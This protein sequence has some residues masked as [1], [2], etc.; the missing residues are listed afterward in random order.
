METRQVLLEILHRL[1]I[2][3]QDT[4]DGPQVV[5]RRDRD[6]NIPQSRTNRQSALAQA[7]D[8]PHIFDAT[9]VFDAEPSAVYVDDCCHF[10]KKGNELLADFVGKAVLS[11]RPDW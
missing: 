9:R 5:L 7:P 11:V 8:R 10:T 4:V 1:V 3:P 2:V 6:A